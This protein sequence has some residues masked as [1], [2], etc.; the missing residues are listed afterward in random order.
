MSFKSGIYTL[1]KQVIKIKIKLD[2]YE[3]HDYINNPISITRGADNII[4]IQLLYRE[5]PCNLTN[6]KVR[7]GIENRKFQIFEIDQQDISVADAEKGLIKVI[8]KEEL[9]KVTGR[10]HLQVQ[11]SQYDDEEELLFRQIWRGFIY[12]ADRHPDE[13]SDR[14]C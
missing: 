6:L 13:L 1:K 5:T 11:I 9:L 14:R 3:T 8:L 10:T 4:Y 12:F 7:I 2:L